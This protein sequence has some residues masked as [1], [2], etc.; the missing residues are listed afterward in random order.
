MA[1]ESSKASTGWWKISISHGNGSGPPCCSSDRPHLSSWHTFAI[2]SPLPYTPCSLASLLRHIHQPTFLYPYWFSYR[3]SSS[4][5]LVQSPFLSFSSMLSLLLHFLSVTA[6]LWQL[7]TFLFFFSPPQWG[8]G[9]AS[10][11]LLKQTGG[12]VVRQGWRH[13]ITNHR[14]LAVAG[15]WCIEAKLRQRAKGQTGPAAL[16]SM[17]IKQQH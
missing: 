15:R 14:L 10:G 1:S 3:H 2:Q 12:R 17:T 4:Q 9:R 7:F 6:E 11:A 5:T 8:N 16:V 13:A